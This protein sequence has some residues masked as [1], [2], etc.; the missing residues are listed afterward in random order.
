[1]LKQRIPPWLA[2]YVATEFV[3]AIVIIYVIVNRG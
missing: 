1:M 2:I 3:A